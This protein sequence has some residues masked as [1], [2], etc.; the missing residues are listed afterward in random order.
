MPLHGLR[1]EDRGLGSGSRSACAPLVWFL[2]AAPARRWHAP[3][4]VPHASLRR[5]RRLSRPPLPPAR[6]AACT[7]RPAWARCAALRAC[8]TCWT[9]ARAWGSCPWTCAP[10]AATSCRPR[11]AST[12]G[13]R[14]ARACSSAA[15]A[16][17]AWAARLVWIQDA[18]L[19]IA[20]IAAYPCQTGAH[21]K[22]HMRLLGHS[23]LA[24]PLPLQ[25][26][27]AQV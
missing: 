24:C 20:A 3:A 5:R 25:G 21:G 11:G 13:A 6:Q 18:C 15:G 17:G 12:C 19:H 23:P 16:A 26:C 14:A 4:R 9:P 7:T 1:N 2:F 8:P 22:P 27:A 10:S